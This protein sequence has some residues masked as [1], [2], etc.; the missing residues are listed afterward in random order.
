M[1]IVWKSHFY[2]FQF[3]RVWSLEL[4]LNVCSLLFIQIA[5]TRVT[6]ST[7]GEAAPETVKKAPIRV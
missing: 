2:F 7:R 1:K 4:V 5:R 3:S 6:T